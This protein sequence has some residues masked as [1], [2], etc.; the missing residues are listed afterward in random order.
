MPMHIVHYCPT[1]YPIPPVGYG[2][3]ER[4]VYWLIRA[5]IAQGLRVSLIANAASGIEQAV[6]G[7][8]L[9]P[10]D[11]D[12]PIAS[13][14]PRDCDVAHLHRMPPDPE[15]IPVPHLI[16]EH[17][18]RGP[19]ARL[20]ANTVFVS[21]SHARIHG[22]RCFVRNGVPVDDY[23]Y[24]EEKDRFLLFLARMEWPHKNARTAM[25]LAIDLDLPLKMSGKYPPWVRPKLWGDWCRH[26]LAVRRLVQRLGYVD[27]DLKLELL[28]RAPVMFHA[29]NWHEP[30]SIVVLE[31]LASGTPVLGTPNGSLPEFIEHGRTG[32]IVEDYAQAREAVREALSFSVEQRRLWAQRCR[33][34]VSRVED[35]ARGYR[36]LYE[37][38]IAGERLSTTDETRPSV[39]RPVVSVL[40]GR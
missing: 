5:Q 13:V 1:A 22:R 19:D 38:V 25:D 15:A 10:C 8:R 7:A 23:R 33:E 14:V 37:K 35:T 36:L 11:R 29:V 16:T 27:G 12:T 34:R 3:T 2:G 9:I 6:P 24:S 40:K 20:L 30:G 4:V 39:A 17:G 26:P 31:S 18:N 21:E 28:A 32:W